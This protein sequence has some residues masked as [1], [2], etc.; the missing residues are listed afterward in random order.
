MTI[1]AQRAIVHVEDALPRDAALI[2]AE[3]VAP[4]DVIVEQAPKQIVRTRDGV[5]VA[6]E[7]KVDVF[8]RHDLRVAAAGRA[9]LHAEARSKAMAHAAR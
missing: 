7:V 6:G 9:A 3:G 2:D 4:V 5:K 8:H 1:D